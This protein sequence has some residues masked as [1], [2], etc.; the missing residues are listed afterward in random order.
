MLLESGESGLLIFLPD[1]PLCIRRWG[2]MGGGNMLY[3]A[4][5]CVYMYQS[6]PDL[7]PHKGAYAVG[8]NRCQ[9]LGLYAFAVFCLVH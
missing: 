6:E 5:I 2:G 1:E 7:S 4:A 3:T 9:C 8:G